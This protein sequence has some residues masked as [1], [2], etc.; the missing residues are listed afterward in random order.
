MTGFMHDKELSRKHFL[1]GS[2]ALVVGFSAFASTAGKAAAATGNTPFSARTPADYLPN[3]QTIDSWIAVTADN[4]VIVTHGEPEF[5]GTPTG[6][7]MLVGEELNTNMDQMIYARP[8][9]WLNSTGGGG[10]SGGISQRSTQIRA[11]AA[12]AKQ[13][14]LNM[15]S[16]QLGVPVSSLTVSGGVVS[17]GGKTATYGQLIGGKNFN[18]TMPL[19]PANSTSATATQYIPGAGITKP[20]SQY[21]LVG[22]QVRRIDIPAKV[23]GTYTYVHNIRVPGMVHARNV[24]PRGASANSSQSHFPL[25]VDP[26]SIS[27]IPGAQVVQINNFLAVWAPKEYDAIQAASQLKVVWKSD[28]KFGDGGSGNYWSWLR[29]AGDTN[30]QNPARYTA[31]TGGVPAALASAAKTVS[32]TYRYHYNNFVPIGPHAAV[33]DVNGTTSATVYP[34]SD[35]DRHRWRRR[36]PH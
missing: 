9:S 28:P 23:N 32:A 21:Q 10:G 7:L 3:L 25:S 31:D 33:A 2:G 30:T 34:G 8:E 27:H 12:Y 15:A 19:D 1:K 36:R 13:Q 29:T 35:A 26:T 4:K 16:T 5:A 18:Y 14:L 22:K 6:I 11:A 17:G 24:R 20:V